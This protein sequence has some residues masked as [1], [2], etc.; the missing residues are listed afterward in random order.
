MA[1][2]FVVDLDCCDLSTLLSIVVLLYCIDW[3]YDNIDRL[4][5]ALP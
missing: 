4:T 3:P 1:T 5:D 2:Y